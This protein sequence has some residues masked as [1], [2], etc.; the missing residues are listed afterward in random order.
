MRCP[1]LALLLSAGVLAVSA[2]AV[3]GGQDAGTDSFPYT[4]IHEDSAGTSRLSDE[5]LR[6]DLVDPG[7]GIQPTPASSLW[8]VRGLRVFCPPPS[9]R[10]DW[11]PVPTRLVNV[12]LSGEVEI[13][14]GDGETRRFGPGSVILGEDTEGRGHRTRV[15]APGGACFAMLPLARSGAGTHTAPAGFLAPDGPPASPPERTDAGGRC[16]VDLRQPYTIRG[17]IEGRLLID[18]RIL[19]EGPCGLPPGQVDEEWIAHGT[20]EGSTGDGPVTG[21]LWYTARV[22]GGGRVEGLMRLTGGL[23]ARL[24]VSGRFEDGELAY[25]MLAPGGAGGMEPSP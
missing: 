18:Y 19:V 17:R 8:P 15:V 16:V 13:E 25:S 14:A 2:P 12:I 1:E 7:R 4:R 5:V 22:A 21:T 9:G 20:F 24:A 23:E 3:A 6:L 10:V 11:H